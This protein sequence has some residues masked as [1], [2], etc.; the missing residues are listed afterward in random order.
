MV[1]LTPSFP[2]KTGS[3]MQRFAFRSSRIIEAT[4]GIKKL[5]VDTKMPI[6]AMIIARPTPC[7]LE[8]KSC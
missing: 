5:K 4:K 7:R 2:D 3:R 8:N 6:K 1:F